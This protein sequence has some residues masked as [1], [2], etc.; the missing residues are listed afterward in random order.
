MVE[1]VTPRTDNFDI[2]IHWK[3]ATRYPILALIAR[4]IY[5]IHVSI[6]AS[7]LVFSTGGRFISPHRNRLP[8]KT[9]EA[10]MCARD[11][12][13]TAVKSVSEGIFFILLILNYIYT[14]GF[15]NYMFKCY[16]NLIIL[17]T[18]FML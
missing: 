11:W 16:D 8:P 7:E 12:L 2:L 17:T 9:L 6:V 1:V 14:L 3:T 10:L 18:C 5:A 13:W 4:D 15:F